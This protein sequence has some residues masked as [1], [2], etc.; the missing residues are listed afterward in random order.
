MLQCKGFIDS[1]QEG[2]GEGAWLVAHQKRIITMNYNRCHSLYTS[3]SWN[4]GWTIWPTSSSCWFWDVTTCWSTQTCCDSLKWSLH[5]AQ[6]WE[7]FG[8]VQVDLFTCA[9]TTHC[10]LW[11]SLVEPG[12]LME[13]DALAQYWPHS[14]LYIFLPLLLIFP[15]LSLVVRISWWLSPWTD[16]LAQVDFEFPARSPVLVGMVDLPTQNWA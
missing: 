8:E 1:F 10:W 15:M 6:I 9:K 11:L 13:L 12:S 16:L 2:F 4:W 7:R 14:L 3:T 5:P